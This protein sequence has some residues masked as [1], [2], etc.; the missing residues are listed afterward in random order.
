[1]SMFNKK[2]KENELNELE[3]QYL[4]EIKSADI[5]YGARHIYYEIVK[6]DKDFQFTLSNYKDYLG[7]ILD[8]IYY[9]ICSSDSKYKNMSIDRVRDISHYRVNGILRYLIARD[10]I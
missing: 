5:V 7:R 4:T 10:R 2:Y 8:V 9:K 1:M 3:R 6:S